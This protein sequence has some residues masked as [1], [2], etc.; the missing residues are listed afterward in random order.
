MIFSFYCD[1][2]VYI[3][4]AVGEMTSS[5]FAIANFFSIIN[6]IEPQLAVIAGLKHKHSIISILF[7][8]FR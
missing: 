3:T 8:A 1:A 2:K 6:R 7:T 4:S 5:K